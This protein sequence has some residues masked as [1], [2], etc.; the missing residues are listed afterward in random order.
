MQLI[1][2]W[3]SWLESDDFIDMAGMWYIRTDTACV[4]A[5]WKKPT[6]LQIWFRDRA[7]LNQAKNYNIGTLTVWRKAR[8]GLVADWRSQWKGYSCT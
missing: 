4:I 3:C 1:S 6:P 2:W 5:A 7:E 8:N